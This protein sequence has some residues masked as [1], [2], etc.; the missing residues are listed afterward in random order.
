MKRTLFSLAGMFAMLALLLVG[1]SKNKDAAPDGMTAPQLT[2]KLIGRWEI[3]DGS[4]KLGSVPGGRGPGGFSLHASAGHKLAD[5]DPGSGGTPASGFV[6]FFPG[7]T[8][9]IFF[10]DGNTIAGS[11]TVEKDGTIKVDPARIQ[12]V[13]FPSE[14]R[15]SFTLTVPGENGAVRQL[16][17]HDGKKADPVRNA[18]ADLDRTARLARA[19]ELVYY[20]YA[21]WEWEKKEIKP[22]VFTWNWVHH[23]DWAF[24]WQNG[25]LTGAQDEDFL[26]VRKGLVNVSPYGT[27]LRTYY[28][29]HGKVKNTEVYNWKW[30]TANASDVRIVIWKP[31]QK[32]PMTADE[33]DDNIYPITKLTV[34]ELEITEIVD[35]GDYEGNIAQEARLKAKT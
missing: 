4:F 13:S 2:E 6:E 35:D 17:V 12:N 8:F 27:Y 29:G 9:I 14:G 19:W 24:T 7:D 11:Y 16:E 33:L 31:N 20:R 21:G 25:T 1:C 28:D 3:P 22:E 15:I 34:T 30:R 18:P 23:P 32:E 5:T 10:A 26:G